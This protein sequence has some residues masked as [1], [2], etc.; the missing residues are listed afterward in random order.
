MDLHLARLHEQ[1]SWGKTQ[2]DETL[3]D[4]TASLSQLGSDAGAAALSRLAGI[5]RRQAMTMAIADVFY[6]L[7]FLFIGIIVMLPLMQ[8]PATGTGGSG[9]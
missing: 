3:A 9:H 6:L 7:T 8:R 4:I 5:V 2:A 1:V